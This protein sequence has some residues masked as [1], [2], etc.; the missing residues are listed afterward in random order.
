MGK[1]VINTKKVFLD[2]GKRGNRLKPKKINCS[3]NVFI[4]QMQAPCYIINIVYYAFV[5]KRLRFALQ[6]EAEA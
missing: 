3:E 1:E 2:I 5:K 6:Y 4:M